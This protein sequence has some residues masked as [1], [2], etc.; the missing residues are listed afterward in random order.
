MNFKILPGFLL[1]FFL[2]ASASAQQG[3]KTITTRKATAAK[4]KP[5]MRKTI[6]AKKDSTINISNGVEKMPATIN[7]PAA[8]T[9]PSMQA[10]NKNITV[11]DL[12]MS[13]NEKKMV[14][15]I[16]LLRSNPKAYVKYINAYLKKIPDPGKSLKN[17]AVELI[18]KLNSLE[19]LV[20]L[21]ISPSLYLDARQFGKELIENNVIEH[22]TLPY[23]E[24]LIFEHDNVRDA[25][26]D[27]LIDD[28][29]E[30]RGHRKNLLNSQKTLVAV[31]EIPGKVDGFSFGYIQEFK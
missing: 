5:V 11:A 25:I 16:N 2:C 15:E 7:K 19:P 29:V 8:K 23:A 30:N 1:F 18:S 6:A 26:I 24:N 12:N 10:A 9:R 22:S 14:D 28:G 4:K 21:V 31:Y 20:M 3:K 17:A 13:D 27:L